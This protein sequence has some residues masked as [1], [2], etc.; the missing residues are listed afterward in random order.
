M[1]LENEPAEHILALIEEKLF[2][3]PEQATTAV[4]AMRAEG[5]D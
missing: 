1:T 2:G 3:P 5:G 4:E